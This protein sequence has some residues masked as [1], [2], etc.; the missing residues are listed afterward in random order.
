MMQ[1]GGWQLRIAAA[2]FRVGWV[3][4]PQLFLQCFWNAIVSITRNFADYRL[5]IGTDQPTSQKPLTSYDS[6]IA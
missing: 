1:L 6:E 2:H 4:T 3:L 5:K